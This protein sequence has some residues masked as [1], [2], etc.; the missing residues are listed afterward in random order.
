MIRAL[1]EGGPADGFELGLASRQTPGYLLLIEGPVPDHH[2]SGMPWIVVGAD[3]DDHWP[4]QAR[5]ERSA[6]G[7]SADEQDVFHLSAV[8]YRFVEAS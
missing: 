1:F 3:F 6:M 4:G 5:Y 2:A 7:L 8:I